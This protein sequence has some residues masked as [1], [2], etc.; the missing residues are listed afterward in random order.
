MRSGSGVYCVVVGV[1]MA[2]WWAVDV[3]RSALARPDRARPEIVLHLAAELVTAGVLAAGGA[4]LIAGESTG[5]ALAGLGMPLY[6]VIA[7]PGYFV[8]R[9]EWAPVVIFAILA[10]LTAAAIVAVLAM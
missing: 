5:L 10:V 6:T 4:L 2:V 7:S 9:R 8:A 1:V 3:R